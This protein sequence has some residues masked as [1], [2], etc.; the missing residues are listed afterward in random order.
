MAFFKKSDQKGVGD[1]A[2]GPQR[3]LKGIKAKKVRDKG[4]RGLKL[5]AQLSLFRG[6]NCQGAEMGRL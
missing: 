6:F 4:H 5:S 3:R 1:G 2:A